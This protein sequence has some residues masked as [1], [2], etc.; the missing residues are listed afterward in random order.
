ME[1]EAKFRVRMKFSRLGPAKNLTHLEQINELRKLAA[2]AGL[3]Y[4][5]VKCGREKAPKMSFGPAISVGYESACEY[6]DLYLTQY[7]PETAIEEKIHSVPCILAITGIKRIPLFFPAIE[8]SVNAV[9]YEMRFENGGVPDAVEVERFLISGRIMYEKTKHSGIKEIINAR[10]TVISMKVCMA[11][12][13]APVLN[14][15]LKIEPKKNIKPEIILQLLTGG[16]VNAANIMR[17]ELYWTDS[18]GKLNK[19]L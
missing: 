9:E 7:V 11:A 16:R 3:P 15:C 17:K 18:S 19:L 6:A 8:A 4:A 5:P 1:N 14:L 10:E 12:P 2:A 13:N